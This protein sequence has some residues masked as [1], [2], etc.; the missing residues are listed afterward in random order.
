[1]GTRSSGPKTCEHA[2]QRERPCAHDIPRGSR[3]DSAVTPLPNIAPSTHRD[4]PA[5]TVTLAQ[6]AD[7]MEFECLVPVARWA[8]F[9]GAT[10]PQGPGFESYAWAS[11]IAASTQKATC[12]V[13]RM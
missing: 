7:E 12:S 4:T 11:G 9:G 2:G 8:G 3:H 13:R 10:N 5:N 6:L 1:M